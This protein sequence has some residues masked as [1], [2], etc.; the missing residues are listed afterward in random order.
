MGQKEVNFIYVVTEHYECEDGIPI[1]A[2]TNE[3][4]ADKYMNALMKEN[5]DKYEGYVYLDIK[6]LPLWR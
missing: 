4:S 2:F 1:A 5:P 3:N 6:K